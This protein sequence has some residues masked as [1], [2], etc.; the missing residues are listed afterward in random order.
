MH[1]STFEKII[2]ME[3]IL[4]QTRNEEELN[5]IKSFLHQH[6]LKARVLSE[7]DKE[8]MLLSRLMEETDYEDVIDTHDFLNKMHN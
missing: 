4:I 8:D 3:T 5:L 1:F 7:D 6:K 2:I